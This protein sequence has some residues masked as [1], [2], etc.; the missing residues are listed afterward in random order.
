MKS[1][2]N[3]EKI[4]IDKRRLDKIIKEIMKNK[5]DRRVELGK[6]WW[7]DIEN[8]VRKLMDDIYII[9]LLIA[10]SIVKGG[11]VGYWSAL[12]YHN[13]CDRRSEVIY[14]QSSKKRGYTRIANEGDIRVIKVYG[15]KI[16]VVNLKEEKIF[17]V[18]R[19]RDED[20][21]LEYAITDKEK[22]I[23]DCLDK[24]K[25]CG[26]LMELIPSLVENMVLEKVDLKKVLEYTVRMNNN[27][28][29]KRLGYISEK[30]GWGIEEEVLKKI[31]KRDMYRRAYLDPGFGGSGKVIRKWGLIDNLPEDVW[32]RE[33]W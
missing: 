26:G 22:T 12:Y 8:Y 32:R 30:L 29:L 4:K 2:L 15:Y 21:G 13:L 27:T 11:V 33:I 10:C 31:P 9:P 19:Y 7:E 16:K 24:P 23:I 18:I 14:V 6:S 1:E 20:T 25:Y 5:L 28:V 17:G 3:E